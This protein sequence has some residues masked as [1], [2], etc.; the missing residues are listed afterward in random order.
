MTE[1][2]L[3]AQDL[4]QIQNIQNLQDE[5]CS[6]PED[7]KIEPDVKHHFAPGVYAREMLIPKGTLII[8]KIHK[9]EHLNIISYGDVCLATFEGVKRIQGHTTMVSPVG[10][11]RVVFANEDTLWTTIHITDETDLDKIEDYVIAKDYNEMKSLEEI[12]KA[13]E[14]L[15]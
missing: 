15:S 3:R 1:L 12:Y 10:V 5:L 8:G 2:A 4:P 14:K 7:L 13:L 11:K 6:W 9:H